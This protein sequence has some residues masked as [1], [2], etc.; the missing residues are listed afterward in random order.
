MICFQFY[1]LSGKHGSQCYDGIF[2]KSL[3]NDNKSALRWYKQVTRPKKKQQ[4]QN[5]RYKVAADDYVMILHNQEC[6]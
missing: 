4:Q 1:K 2:H 5:F 6:S 3:D